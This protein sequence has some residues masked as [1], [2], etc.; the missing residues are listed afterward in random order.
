MA[1]TSAGTTCSASSEHHDDSTQWGCQLATDGKYVPE[2]LTVASYVEWATN[3]EGPGA[4]LKLT[5]PQVYRIVWMKIVGR[6][7]D[8]DKAKMVQIDFDQESMEVYIIRLLRN[9]LTRSWFQLK[10]PSYLF[11]SLSLTMRFLLLACCLCGS[12]FDPKKTLQLLIF[13]AYI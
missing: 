6:K 8:E 4:W 5:F 9:T 1:L 3:S 2:N 13:L 11:C 10:L 12:V 7:S